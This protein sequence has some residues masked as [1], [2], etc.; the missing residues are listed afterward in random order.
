MVKLQGATIRPIIPRQRLLVENLR[1]W[2]Q[3]LQNF[4]RV[5]TIITINVE[6]CMNKWAK[7]FVIFYANCCEVIVLIIISIC[8]VFLRK[9]RNFLKFS[10]RL[11]ARK[12]NGSHIFSEIKVQKTWV[13]VLIIADWNLPRHPGKTFCVQKCKK[14]AIKNLIVGA[15]KQKWEATQN[16]FY[17]DF[18]FSGDSGFQCNGIHPVD[19]SDE[20]VKPIEEPALP[21][22]NDNTRY[23]ILHK[24]MKIPI[25]IAACPF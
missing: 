9:W 25:P 10:P 21:K 11:G 1:K 14:V 24:C 8:V 13:L 16:W 20:D 12:I 19:I 2:C 23:K 3:F 22:E 4:A 17:I 15:L 5:E 7:V 18:I 6:N